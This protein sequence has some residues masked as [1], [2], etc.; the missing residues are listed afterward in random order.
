MGTMTQLPIDTTKHAFHCELALKGETAAVIVDGCY[1]VASQDGKAFME[2]A[3]IQTSRDWLNTINARGVSGGVDQQITPR[4]LAKGVT[5]KPAPWVAR[6]AQFHRGR[7]ISGLLI[8][9]APDAAKP[10]F[11]N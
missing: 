5:R 7:I 8:G 4:W 9:I 2:L 1:A 3:K 6:T 11:D 10:G